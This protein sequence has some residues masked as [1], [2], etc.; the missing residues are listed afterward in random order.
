MTAV[1]AGLLL[2]QAWAFEK[3]LGMVHQSQ[4]QIPVIA[5]VDVV[6]VG[7]TV[8]AVAAAESAAKAGGKVFVVAP[9]LYLGED[10]CAKLRLELE[11]NRYAAVHYFLCYACP[12]PT[13]YEL[14]ALYI[15]YGGKGFR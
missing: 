2:Q 10:L 11:K 4:R 7:A 8:A 9:R 5:S 13:T 1:I 14:E 3:S 15:Y 12:F 6:V